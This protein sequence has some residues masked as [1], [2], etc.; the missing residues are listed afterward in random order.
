MND[1]I[2]H[3]GDDGVTLPEVTFP[4][5]VELESFGEEILHPKGGGQCLLNGGGETTSMTAAGENQE[6]LFL[7]GDVN[8]GGD[9]I[10]FNGCFLYVGDD[11]IS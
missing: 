5:G 1:G 2:I 8:G 7:G 3:F 10:K 9:N 6:L 11:S 4:E